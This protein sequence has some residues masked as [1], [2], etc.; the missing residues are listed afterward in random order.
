MIWRMKADDLLKKAS[1]NES[2]SAYNKSI[3]YDPYAVKAWL[4]K[5]KVLVVLE[6][7]GEAAVVFAKAIKLDPSN[8]DTLVL[9][10]DA[11]NASAS[12]K[13]AVASYT[14]AL[15]L[16]PNLAG[17]KEKIALSEMAQVAILASPTPTVVPETPVVKARSES[18][19]A[20]NTTAAP[21]TPVGVN[22]APFPGI[23]AVLGVIVTGA[24]ILM[25]R[26]L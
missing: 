25:R 12:Y 7:P 18:V 21:I 4:G 26:K 13:E 22:T 5:G 16:N 19:G 1:Y 14:R 15:A 10:G 11:Q 2:L 17:V 8:A 3:G 9:L 6:N 23:L 20:T 24:V